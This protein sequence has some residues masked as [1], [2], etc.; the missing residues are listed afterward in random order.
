MAF[1]TLKMFHERSIFRERIVW[2]KILNIFDKKEATAADWSFDVRWEPYFSFFVALFFFLFCLGAAEK[3]IPNS[4]LFCGISTFFGAL[5]FVA[6]TDSTD[7]YA[8]VAI[9]A[10]S[11][12]WFVLVYFLL[13]LYFLVLR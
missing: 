4:V 7:K 11:I 1:Y 3:V 2:K 5:T 9:I 10:N 12:S 8:M 6:I 13:I